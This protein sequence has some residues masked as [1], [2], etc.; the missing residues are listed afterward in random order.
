MVALDR[1]FG[2]FAN[3]WGHF[4]SIFGCLEFLFGHFVTL[5]GCS[6]LFFVIFQQFVFISHLFLSVFICLRSFCISFWWFFSAD[7]GD[8]FVHFCLSH[9]FYW[10]FLF[11]LLSVC[12]Q[13]SIIHPCLIGSSITKKT[14]CCPPVNKRGVTFGKKQENCRRYDGRHLF[15]WLTV[16]Q[17]LYQTSLCYS[18][19]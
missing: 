10:S 16:L 9:V 11:F 13:I 5:C 17:T 2:C 18:T 6:F 12:L 14:K 15:Y 8:F 1:F 19:L 4:T 7:C 3:V